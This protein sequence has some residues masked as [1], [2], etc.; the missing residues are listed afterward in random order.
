MLRFDV[1]VNSDAAMSFATRGIQQT[2]CHIALAYNVLKNGRGYIKGTGMTTRTKSKHTPH[3]CDGVFPTHLC[4]GRLLIPIVDGNDVYQL[5]IL[6]AS[7]LNPL[8]NAYNASVQFLS[9]ALQAG[10][11]GRQLFLVRARMARND[12]DRAKSTP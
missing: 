9:C 4:R 2:I 8:W 12:N 3:M 5:S 7:R 10:S 11:A 1:Q 6:S